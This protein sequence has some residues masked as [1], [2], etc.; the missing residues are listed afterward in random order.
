MSY[1]CMRLLKLTVENGECPWT[2]T[3][4]PRLSPQINETSYD[5]AEPTCRRKLGNKALLYIDGLL[6]ACMSRF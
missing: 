5:F 1:L 6:W 2:F 4:V 3:L